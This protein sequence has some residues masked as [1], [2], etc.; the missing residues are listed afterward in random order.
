ML[1]YRWI[2]KARKQRAEDA[3]TQEEGGSVSRRMI[4]LL[5]VVSVLAGEVVDR[6]CVGQQ[7]GRASCRERVYV[8]V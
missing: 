5:M 7:I 6:A 4:Q 3:D 2:M 8:L 1:S